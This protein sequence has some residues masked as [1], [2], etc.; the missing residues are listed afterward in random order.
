MHILIVRFSLEGLSHA[1]FIASTDEAAQHWAQIPGLIS[2]QWLSSEE[3]NTYGG[4]Y[5]FESKEAMQTYKDSELCVQLLATP[6]FTN[7]DVTDY[8][9]IE[10]ASCITGAISC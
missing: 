10:N 5:L 2:K 6:S 7:F 8:E 4:V 1:D 3:T 9:M